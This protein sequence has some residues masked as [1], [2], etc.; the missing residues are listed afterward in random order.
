MHKLNRHIYI[1][2]GKHISS[3]NFH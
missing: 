1:Y 2:V 3:F